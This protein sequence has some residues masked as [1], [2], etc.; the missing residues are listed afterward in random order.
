MNYV[1]FKH[2]VLLTGGGVSVESG[3]PVYRNEDEIWTRK[4]MENFFRP[5]TF[6]KNPELVHDF[7]NKRR[8]DLKKI[9][10]NKTHC[11]I[12]YLQ[13]QLLGSRTKLTIITKN[14]DDLHEKA[15]TT[16]VIHI[17]GDLNSAFC[18]ICNIRI[19]CLGDLS[20]QTICSNCKNKKTMRPD[21]VWAGEKPYHMDKIQAALDE[22]DLFVSIGTSGSVYPT[23]DFVNLAKKTG[24]VT[25][26]LNQKPS[27]NATSFDHTNYGPAST[28]VPFWVD[29]FIHGQPDSALHPLQ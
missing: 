3:I 20:T 18:T 8:M 15:G 29:T 19:K 7:Y 13:D 23:A 25:V 28:I 5:D 12:A 21:I 10:P 2:V 4:E 9:Q 6:R 26:E 24:A 16:D 27:A 22:C 11:H 14:V 1:Q 17:L